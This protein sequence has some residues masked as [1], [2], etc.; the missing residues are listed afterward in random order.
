[1]NGE[2]WTMA[3]TGLALLV[4]IAAFTAWL[5]WKAFRAQD[6]AWPW[7][8]LAGM[9]GFAL[10]L[11]LTMVG[12]LW[13]HALEDARG[14]RLLGCRMSVMDLGNGM[15]MYAGDNNDRGPLANWT[16]GMSGYVDSENHKCTVS[17]APY[18]FT[19]NKA[20]VGA[21]YPDL[22]RAKAPV[23]FDGPG[24]ENSVGGVDAAVYRHEGER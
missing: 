20:F 14:M 12:L 6:W 4:G 15:L 16:D 13:Q 21:L 1:M 19:M 23:I 5:L 22:A 3:I 11:F 7:R 8:A 2:D 10:L 18:A 17:S 9:V 24:G